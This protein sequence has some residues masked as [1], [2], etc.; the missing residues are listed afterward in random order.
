MSEWNIEESTNWL[1]HENDQWYQ[2]WEK[3]KREIESERLKECTFQPQ[4]HTKSSAIAMNPY[5]I[6]NTP[7]YK[8]V[9]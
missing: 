4:I 2:K 6:H 7:I 8:W 5:K 9:D 3:L 1:Y